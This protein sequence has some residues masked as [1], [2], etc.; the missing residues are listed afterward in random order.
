MNA[1]E[2]VYLFYNRLK[3]IC[4]LSDNYEIIIL[5]CGDLGWKA[6]LA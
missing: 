6:V 5:N 2:L 1:D 4:E 3:E